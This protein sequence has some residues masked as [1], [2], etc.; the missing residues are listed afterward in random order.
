MATAPN[1]RNSP[2]ASGLYTIVLDGVS[3]INLGSGFSAGSMV[4]NGSAKLNGTNL[5]LTDGR[6]SEAASAWYN[7]PVNIQNFTTDFSFQLTPGSSSTADGM[8]FAMQANNTTA[9]GPAG[10]GLGY[11]GIPNSVAV[12]FDLY[13]NA[14]EGNNSTGLYTNGASPTTP[15]VD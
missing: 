5:E 15:F 8:T 7:V 10:G 6:A 4:L 11:G 9:V 14:G 3:S 1:L 13:S 12:K 2:M